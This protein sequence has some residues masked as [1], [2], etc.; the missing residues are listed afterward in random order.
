M[1]VNS[2]NSTLLWSPIE[3]WICLIVRTFLLQQGE[4]LAPCTDSV[5]WVELVFLMGSKL[6]ENPTR[7]VRLQEILPCFEVHIEQVLVESVRMLVAGVHQS[8]H[9]V[10]FD[11]TNLRA[12]VSDLNLHITIHTCE[13]SHY[14]SVLQN[15]LVVGEISPDIFKHGQRLL[16]PLRSQ[17]SLG[18]SC[19]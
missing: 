16:L 5:S 2:S 12:S 17:H 10:V 4:D 18:Y 19:F 1:F 3:K 11:D 14:D 15:L 7:A 8:L 13:Y 9:I 6:L